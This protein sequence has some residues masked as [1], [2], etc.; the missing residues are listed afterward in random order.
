MKSWKC[1][2]CGYNYEGEIAPDK[3]PVCDAPGEKFIEMGDVDLVGG[4][5]SGE[6]TEEKKWKCTVCGYIHSGLTPPDKCP[7]CNAP[8]EMFI[9]LDKNGKEVGHLP[10]SDVDSISEKEVPQSSLLFNRLADLL[11]RHHIHPIS[12]H[13]PNGILPVVVSFL[14]V[15]VYFNLVSLEVAALYNLIVVLLAMPLVLL[16]GYLEWQKNYKGIKTAVFIIKIIC[17]LVVL[18]STSVLV[19]W[20]IIDSE[21]IAEGSP[22]KWIYLGIAVLLLGAAGLAGHLGGKLVFGS[23]G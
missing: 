9:E 6:E 8:A 5:N 22:V 1:S 16:T 7:V 12:V 11:V 13:F 21:V 19:F 14:A 4:E 23:R 2:V 18:V 15:S 17:G 3:C 20:R 10:V